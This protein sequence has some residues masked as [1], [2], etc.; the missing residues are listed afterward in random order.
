M[1]RYQLQS[2]V[3]DNRSYL[4][5]LDEMET[6]FSARKSHKTQRYEE[7]TIREF[8]D[9]SNG[10]G[11]P[12]RGNYVVCG[13]SN[14]PMDIDKA[15][16]SRFSKGI[17]HCKGPVTAEQKAKLLYINLLEGINAGYIRIKDWQAIG[18]LALT[19][20]LGGRDLEQAALDLIDSS[21]TNSFPRDFYQLNFQDKLKLIKEHHKVIGDDELV[22]QLY[23]I[24]NKREVV[25]QTSLNFEMGDT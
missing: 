2:I 20:Q 1:L 16:R 19:L 13:A 12:N 4:I 9:F 14:R 6:K 8:L 24:A 5:F 23:L 11:Y 22:K 7:K 18:E 15:I 17:F 3:N 10:L 25:A 21:R